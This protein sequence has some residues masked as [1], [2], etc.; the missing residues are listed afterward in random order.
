MRRWTDQQIL[1]A[2]RLWTRQRG[3][4]PRTSDWQPGNHG[5]DPGTWPSFMTVVRHFGSWT[6]GLH[7]AGVLTATGHGGIP[8]RPR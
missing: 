1:A 8:R 3:T 4:P 2:I 6:A 7:E 5:W